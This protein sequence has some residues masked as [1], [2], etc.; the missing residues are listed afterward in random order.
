MVKERAMMLKSNLLK[1]LEGK[2]TKNFSICSFYLLCPR[3]GNNTTSITFNGKPVGCIKDGVIDIYDFD[4]SI[5]KNEVYKY[6]FL[7]MFKDE[8]E[9]KKEDNKPEEEGD[10]VRDD[11]STKAKAKVPV[12]KNVKKRVKKS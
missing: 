2:L 4:E 3:N 6:E 10:S 5:W 12:R 1:A 8:V 11:N 7:L 9:C